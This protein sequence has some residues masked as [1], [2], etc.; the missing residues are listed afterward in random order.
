VSTSI[1]FGIVALARKLLIA[2]WRDLETG[3]PPAG[4][5]VI[6]WDKKP[7]FAGAGAA[8]KAS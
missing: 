8:R 7:K 1:A 4:A 6:G 3:E 2:L 5:E